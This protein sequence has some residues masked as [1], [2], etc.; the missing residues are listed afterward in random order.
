MDT[1]E[2]RLLREVSFR[3]SLT[4]RFVGE[5]DITLETKIDKFLGPPAPPQLQ[6]K[7]RNSKLVEGSDAVFSAF[8]PA[9]PRPRVS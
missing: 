8:I 7:P 3:E 9:N 6:S 5:S 4:R 2:Y 1:F